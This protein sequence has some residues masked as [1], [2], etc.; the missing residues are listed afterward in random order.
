MQKL[1]QVLKFHVFSYKQKS[2]PFHYP[3]NIIQ[4]VQRLQRRQIIHIQI[5]YL[6]AYLAQHWVVE[7]KEAE[8]HAAAR[9]SYF[10]HRL[11]GDSLLAVVRF[12]LSQYVVARFTMLL[13]IPAILAT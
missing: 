8:L 6:I 12:Q 1:V 4:L 5:Q 10:R 3:L 11:V 2:L 9:L 13:G 7:L